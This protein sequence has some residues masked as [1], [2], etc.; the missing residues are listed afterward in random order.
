M[1]PSDDRSLR[2][3]TCLPSERAA[4]LDQLLCVY[5]ADQRSQLSARLLQTTPEA[6]FCGLFGAFRN[7][8]LCGAVWAQP[9]AGRTAVV[10]M[11]RIAKTA[12][13]DDADAL[14]AA[15]VEFCRS[16]DVQLVQVMLPTDA[17]GDAALLAGRGFT[18]LAD[19]L[20]LVSHRL[21]FPDAPPA[22]QLEFE[23]YQESEHARLVEL[24]EATYRHSLDCPG[25]EAARSL[26]DVIAGY[27]AT[28]TFAAERWLFVRHAGQDVGCLLLADH[29]TEDQW[30]LVYLGV[31]PTARGRGLGTLIARHA[32]WLAQQAGR[33]RI[34]LAVDAANRPAVDMYAEAG[35]IAWDRTSIFIL[36]LDV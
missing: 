10:W 19:L 2:I 34:V 14:L 27:R 11:P 7:E 26:D 16:R 32:Q 29:P 4:V 30:E 35:F 25:L 15:A 17:G 24:I 8:Q 28:G 31:I 12:N 33:A 9:Q 3:T 23:A 22:A 5:P 1:P 21:Q 20:Y 18:H 13:S 36:R 6:Q